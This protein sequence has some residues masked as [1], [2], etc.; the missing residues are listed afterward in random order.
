[1]LDP[2]FA[3]ANLSPSASPVDV[4][5]QLGKVARDNNEDT[6]EF[7]SS[8]AFTRAAALDRKGR[9]EEAWQLLVPA[10]EAIFARRRKDLSD[11]VERQR[12]S[13]QRLKNLPI[14]NV[15][16]AGKND[17]RSLFIL[18]PSRSGKTS[19]ERLVAALD[20]VKRGYENPIVE[21]AIRRTFQS[22][23]LLTS[24]NFEN[25]PD[26]L[27]PLCREIYLEELQQRAGTATVFTNTHPG[28]IH[29]VARLVSI[30]PNARFIFVKRDVEDTILRMYMRRYDRGNSHSYDLAAARDHVI[31]YHQMI[32]LLSEKLPKHT[33]VIRYEDMVANPTATLQTAAELCELSMQHGPLPTIGD[34]RGCALPYRA[35]M[36]S[37]E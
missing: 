18:G 29:D 11:A 24:N 20:G 13:V 25:L 4:L 34:D 22:S 5:D 19:V 12:A 37:Q 9:Y 28:R 33:R 23:A 10:N 6:S 1:M 3:I 8:V 32:D 15:N 17:I 16:V 35:L 31:W 21:N 26:Q 27:L 36:T 7:E 30:L 2:V 14:R